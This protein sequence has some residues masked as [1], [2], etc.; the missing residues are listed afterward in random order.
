MEAVLEGIGEGGVDMSE[1]I[2]LTA[3]GK[4]SSG[5]EAD[6]YLFVTEGDSEVIEPSEHEITMML[7]C[8][9]SGLEL[10]SEVTSEYV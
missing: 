7:A 1:K 2:K 10:V 5:N 9:R 3:R 4:D 6:V 8:Q